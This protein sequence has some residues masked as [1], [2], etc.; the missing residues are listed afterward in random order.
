MAEE[1]TYEKRRRV[2]R[3]SFERKVGVLIRGEYIVTQSLQIG[4]RGMLIYS[5]RPLAEGQQ[6]VIA[7][8]LP[9]FAH[10]VVRATV[11]YILKPATGSADVRY[12]LQFDSI[13]FS[14]RRQIRNYVAAK[15]AEEVS[16]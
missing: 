6:V 3:R 13:D 7:F 12:G 5:P 14:A 8:R 2:P 1:R 11:R 9:G 4:E 10:V 15:E 16:L